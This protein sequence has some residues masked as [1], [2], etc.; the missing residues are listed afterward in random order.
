MSD[1]VLDP[2]ALTRLRRIGGDRLVHAMMSAFVENGAQKVA[3]GR[4]GAEARD[5]AALS[6][7]AH[8]LKSS[9]G[10]V[11]ASTLQQVAQK[12]EREAKEADA[13][14]LLLATQLSAAFERAAAAAIEARDAVRG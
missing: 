7:A 8:A 14:L 4:A 3:A 10:N 1:P 11:G 12:V 13:N 5:G 6:D 9:A 2:Q